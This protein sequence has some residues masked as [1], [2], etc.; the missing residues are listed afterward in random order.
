MNAHRKKIAA[1]NSGA[2]LAE[3]ARRASTLHSKSVDSWLACAEVLLEARAVASHGEWSGFLREA[4]IPQRT[5]RR[6]LTYARCGIENG[7][8]AVLTYTEI[9]AVIAS[10]RNDH[11]TTVE[12]LHRIR[13]AANGP[14]DA[15][16][17]ELRG[18]VWEYRAGWLYEPE[19]LA[20]QEWE[21]AGAVVEAC[22]KVA[23]EY[24]DDAGEFAMFIADFP[25]RP[26]PASTQ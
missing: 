18:A 16:P 15:I 7:H 12:R 23:R 9:D 8:M 11:W 17:G 24:E 10:A 6:M 21:Y 19:E 1:S 14:D 2:V 26:L 4:G 20:A 25:E 3:L 22:I 13:E 5:A